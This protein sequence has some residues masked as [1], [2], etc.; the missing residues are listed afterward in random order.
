MKCPLFRI[1]V[2]AAVSGAVRSA[3]GEHRALGELPPLAGGGILIVFTAWWICFAAPAHQRLTS[4][5][6]ALNRLAAPRRCGRLVSLAPTA[7]DWW[8]PRR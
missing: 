2:A 4:R 8:P 1:V 3:S 5:R 6:E 7:R